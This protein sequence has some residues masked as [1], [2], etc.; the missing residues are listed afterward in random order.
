MGWVRMARVFGLNRQS[1]WLAWPGR[2]EPRGGLTTK[3]RAIRTQP[4]GRGRLFPQ[5]RDHPRGRRDHLPGRRWGLGG[6]AL[7]SFV[8]QIG[9]MATLTPR[10]ENS[11]TN[12]SARSL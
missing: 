3:T 1:Q 7:L 12:S 11:S 2:A 6:L 8:V 10:A 9:S 5:N 4:V